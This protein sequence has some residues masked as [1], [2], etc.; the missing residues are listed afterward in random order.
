M[1][2][3]P[4]ICPPPDREFGSCSNRPHPC[5]A[6]YAMVNKSPTG[7]TTIKVGV[8]LKGGRE[9]SLRGRCRPTILTGRFNL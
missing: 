5:L 7:L 2:G 1:Y 6:R 3:K 9:I 4:L 8:G